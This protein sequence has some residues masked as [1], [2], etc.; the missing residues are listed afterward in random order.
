MKDPIEV[1]CEIGKQFDIPSAEAAKFAVMGIG[2]VIWDDMVRSVAQDV[3]KAQDD[4]RGPEWIL[5]LLA[6]MD[7]ALIRSVR[8]EQRSLLI[9]AASRLGAGDRATTAAEDYLLL[10]RG[11][12]Q[13]NRDVVRSILSSRRTEG[14]LREELYNALGRGPEFLP[15]VSDLWAYRWHWVGMALTERRAGVRR[16]RYGNPMDGR[17][18]PFCRWLVRSGRTVTIGSIMEQVNKLERASVRDD[19]ELSIKSWPMLSFIGT[20]TERDFGRLYNEQSA[21][22]P[23]FHWFCRTWL[24]PV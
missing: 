4:E 12:W 7:R 3:D 11:R 19:I 8:P 1:C 23:P 18:T 15:A 5:L 17:T 10:L 16:F 9:Q 20:E 6:L 13:R 2:Q 22:T 21:L 14:I 24:I